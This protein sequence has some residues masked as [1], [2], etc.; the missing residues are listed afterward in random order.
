[1]YPLME[2]QVNRSGRAV[3]IAE[4]T[5]PRDICQRLMGDVCLDAPVVP[6]LSFRGMVL[7]TGM[8][9][10]VQLGI[11][12]PRATLDFR[13]KP[14]TEQQTIDMMEKFTAALQANEQGQYL[15]VPWD[16]QDPY[17]TDDHDRDAWDALQELHWTTCN[18]PYQCFPT[19]VPEIKDFPLPFYLKVLTYCHEVHRLKLPP[20]LRRLTLEG[21]RCY[22]GTQFP[23]SLQHLKFTNGFDWK[24][25][26]TKLPRHLECLDLGDS[27]NQPSPRAADARYRRCVRPALQRHQ[28]A[29]RP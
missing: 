1:M 18:M 14:I 15:S 23:E 27:Y 10:V 17:I 5:T 19:W 25:L 7:R 9:I 13:W 22:S 2:V 21:N 6:Q 4:T 26:H 28:A 20:N 8:P 12:M 3:P 29:S 24:L 16:G 11:D